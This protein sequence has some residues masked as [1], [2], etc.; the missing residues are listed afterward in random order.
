MG[1]MTE[2]NHTD[3]VRER[4]LEQLIYGEYP[5]G[6]TFKLREMLESEDF[7]GISQ[8]PCREALLQLVAKDILVGQRGFSVRVPIPSVEHLAEVR[9]I[10]NKLEVMAAVKVMA[11]WTPEGIEKLEQLHRQMLAAKAVGDVRQILR[12]NV[13]FHFALYGEDRKS[14]LMTMIRTLWA[15]T[16]PSIGF[17]YEE[18]RGMDV[19]GHHPHDDVILALCTQDRAL[20]EKAISE[21]LSV[22]GVKIL[23]VLRETVNPEALAVQPF[24]KMQLLRTRA[25]YGRKILQEK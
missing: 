13:Q 25:K 12:A 1:A 18:G 14:Y 6:H 8:T 9:A 21:D 10:R 17:L 20:L 16:G 15:I 11:G 23:Q 5:P 4:L 3:V 24:R 7:Q 22:T 19:S 2:L